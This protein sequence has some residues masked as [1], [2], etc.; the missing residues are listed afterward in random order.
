MDD[1]SF[2]EWSALSGKFIAVAAGYYHYHSF[3]AAPLAG[4]IYVCGPIS[5]ASDGAAARLQLM[6]LDALASRAAAAG[7]ISSDGLRWDRRSSRVSSLEVYDIF[8]YI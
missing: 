2:R 1:R 3:E 4:G 8:E 6:V 7:N 5:E